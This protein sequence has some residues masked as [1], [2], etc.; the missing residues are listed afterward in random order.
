M[1]A[2][3]KFRAKPVK[4]DGHHFPS[5]LE[6]AYFCRLELLK[7]AGEVVFFL[8]QIPFHLPGGAKYVCDFIVFYT[9]G[10]VKF[11]DAKGVETSEFK[12]KKKMVEALYPVTIETVKR[13]QF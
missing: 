1:R 5:K 10:S 2:R 3:H 8:R 13:G 11:I 6:H 12:M 4:D 9:D 7:R